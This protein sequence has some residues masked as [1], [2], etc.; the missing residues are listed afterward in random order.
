MLDLL[1]KRVFQANMDLV[2]HGLVT[3][4]WGNVSGIDRSKHCV[5]IKPSGVEYEAMTA[6]DM[7]V[8]DMDGTVVDGI[9][10]P[11]S[12]LPN[13]SSCTGLFP[14]SAGLHTRTACTERCLHKRAARSR[15][16]ARP[17]RIISTARS[18]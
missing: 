9:L 18:L 13:T 6:Q 8:V 7:T 3:R 17:M 14:E 10:R 11:S 16:S 5:V 2:R 15:V 1:K 12:D 4:T